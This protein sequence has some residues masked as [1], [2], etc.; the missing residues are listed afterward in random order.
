MGS[1]MCI[2]D[3]LNPPFR[4]GKCQYLPPLKHEVSSGRIDKTDEDCELKV[5][6]GQYSLIASYSYLRASTGSTL[7]AFKAGKNVAAAEIK[8]PQKATPKTSDQ[9]ILAGMPPDI[10]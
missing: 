10:P 2:R 8:K 4:L 1:E 5:W 6:G 3:R 9:T 7:E